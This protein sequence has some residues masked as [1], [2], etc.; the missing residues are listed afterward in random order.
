MT[1]AKPMQC[2]ATEQTNGLDTNRHNDQ[3]PVG[4]LSAL[5]LYDLDGFTVRAFDIL[6]RSLSTT[7]FVFLFNFDS[8]FRRLSSVCR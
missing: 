6:I 7:E 3:L 4:L 5:C 1:F 2:A 8:E